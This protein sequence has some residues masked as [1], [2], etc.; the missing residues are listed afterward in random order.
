MCK[1]LV[2]HH[3]ESSE[4][5]IHFLSTHTLVETQR[6]T[7]MK[8][9]GNCKIIYNPMRYDSYDSFKKSVLK[10]VHEQKVV[11]IYF[12]IKQKWR[13]RFV[14]EY[15][16]KGRVNGAL[17]GWFV[18]FGRSDDPTKI[19]QSLPYIWHGCVMKFKIEET[20]GR[21]PVVR[22]YQPKEENNQPK[23][24]RPQKTEQRRRK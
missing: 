9:H 17:I 19:S 21:A 23:N 15:I 11:G 24:N 6:K 7:I 10:L 18:G 20:F 8:M 12:V 14:D 2:H 22:E 16:M 4:T 3:L 1:R 13:K 5:E